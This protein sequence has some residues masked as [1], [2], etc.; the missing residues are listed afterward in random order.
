MIQSKQQKYG[1]K[2]GVIICTKCTKSIEKLT[3]QKCSSYVFLKINTFNN[4]KLTKIIQKKKKL[5]FLHLCY[6]PVWDFTTDNQ[7]Y[8]PKITQQISYK[9]ELFL[10]TERVNLIKFNSSLFINF[11]TKNN[12]NFYV[13]KVLV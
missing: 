13:V 3:E 9:I 5:N 11:G 1:T 2:I 6:I 4:L 10:S 7:L 8:T 12:Q